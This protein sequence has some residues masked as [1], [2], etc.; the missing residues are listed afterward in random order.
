MFQK[1]FRTLLRTYEWTLEW[2][3]HTIFRTDFPT[4]ERRTYKYKTLTFLCSL[5]Y[6]AIVTR[7]QFMAISLE[8]QPFITCFNVSREIYRNLSVLYV[9]YLVYMYR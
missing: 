2:T 1:L 5:P 8:T 3:V 9:Y 6:V 4:M 7:I